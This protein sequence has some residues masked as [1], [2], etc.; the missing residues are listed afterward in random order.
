VKK[1]ILFSAAV[2]SASCSHAPEAKGPEKHYTLT[3]KVVSVDKS[4][5]TATIDAAAIPNYMDAMTME[6][7]VKSKSE[8]DSLKAG[9]EITATID[10]AADESYT[11]SNIKAK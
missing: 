11:L 4:H 1:L 10:V 8:F 3:G 6:Y 2:I 5:Q 9:E 7:P